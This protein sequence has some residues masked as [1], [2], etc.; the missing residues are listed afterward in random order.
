[1]CTFSKKRVTNGMRKNVK[2]GS[3]LLSNLGGAQASQLNPI[4]QF[5]TDLS[6]VRASKF[7]QIRHQV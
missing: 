5:T 6:P 3:E 4:Q 1:M 7:L 2:S